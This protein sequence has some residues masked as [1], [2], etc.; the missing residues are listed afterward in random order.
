VGYATTKHV[1]QKGEMVPISHKQA[2]RDLGVDPVQLCRWKKDVDKIHSLHKG[3]RKGIVSHSAQFPEIED[4][5]VARS[6][7]EGYH[8]TKCGKK[9]CQGLRILVR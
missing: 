8:V 3:S 9:C 5:L 4:R 1:H 2:C 6:L 7:L